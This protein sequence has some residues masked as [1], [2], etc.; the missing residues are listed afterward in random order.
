M[1]DLYT[2]VYDLFLFF[3]VYLF[4]LCQVLFAA[5][6]LL[7]VAYE[8]LHVESSSLTRYQTWASAL[9]MEL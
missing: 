4:C 1:G 9:G 3:N 7:A 8:L 6:G 2:Y 5:C